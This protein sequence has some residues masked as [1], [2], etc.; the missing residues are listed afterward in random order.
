MKQGRFVV[1]WST[2]LGERRQVSFTDRQVALTFVRDVWR[3]WQPV[4]DLEGDALAKVVG[5]LGG[6]MERPS[7]ERRSLPVDR[8]KV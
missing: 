1:R 3:P 8:R 2:G 5:L 4:R 7:V 6:M